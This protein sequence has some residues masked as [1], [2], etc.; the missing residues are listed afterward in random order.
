MNNIAS[1][2][3]DF[4]FNIV[5]NT[6]PIVIPMPI[7]NGG[8]ISGARRRKKLEI[9]DFAW[10]GTFSKLA[11]TITTDGTDFNNVPPNYFI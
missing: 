8:M 2:I 7:A 6:N 9:T 5:G 4:R 1:N 10:M 11:Q 3:N